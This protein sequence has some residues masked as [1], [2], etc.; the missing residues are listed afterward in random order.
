MLGAS[1]FI[2]STCKEQSSDSTITSRDPRDNGYVPDEVTA[3]KVA[4]AIWL[5]IYGDD[6]YNKRPFHAKLKNNSI[7]II[8]GSLEPDELGGVPYAEIQKSDC[9]V[10]RVI[11]TK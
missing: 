1:I 4:E 2:N 6:I 9:R 7:W 3:I 5:P 11:H 10:L 8:Q